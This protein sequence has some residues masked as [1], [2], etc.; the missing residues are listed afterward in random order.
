MAQ[1]TKRALHT[2]LNAHNNR[3]VRAVIDQI[4][5]KQGIAADLE[6]VSVVDA[7]GD[8]QWVEFLVEAAAA[9]GESM[10]LDVLRDGVS[11]LDDGP[12]TY[13][14]TTGEPGVIVRLP[15]IPGTHLAVGE[16]LTISRDYTAGGAATPIG[17]NTVMIGV[18]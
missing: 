12:F 7:A 15:A 1:L 16:V 3:L 18:A 13:D 8:V 4:K 11:I 14:D 2:P 5:S 6:D 10:V 9:S 17:A